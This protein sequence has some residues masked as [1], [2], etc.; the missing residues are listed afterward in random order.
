MDAPL[1]QTRANVGAEASVVAK[2][3]KMAKVTSVKMM[4]ITPTWT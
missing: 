4:G 3:Q 2:Q 1:R